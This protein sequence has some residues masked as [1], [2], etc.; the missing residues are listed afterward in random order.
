MRCNSLQENGNETFTAKIRLGGNPGPVHL[1]VCDRDGPEDSSRLEA[2]RLDIVLEAGPPSCIM[3]D[4][5]S[6]LN[7]G[8][9]SAL[10]ELRVKA[11]DN[12]GNKAGGSFEVTMRSPAINSH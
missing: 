1:H 2:D 3:F 8:T 5:P 11:T 9:H 10:G 4:A 12:Y 6:I 7:C